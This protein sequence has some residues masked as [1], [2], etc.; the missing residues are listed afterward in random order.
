[1]VVTAKDVARA[2]GV[3]QATVSYV[4]NANPN[5]RISE[6]T[7]RRV[8][9]AAAALGYAPSAAA[10]ALRLGT[11]DAVLL[12]LPNIPFG[13][14]VAHII[15]QLTDD[16]E[17]IGLTLVTRRIREP[18]QALNAVRQLRPIAVI[19]VAALTE[20]EHDE[21]RRSGIPISSSVL[22][23]T[24]DVGALTVPQ[25]TIGQLQVE[26]LAARGHRVLGYAAP[27]DDR[28][29]EFLRLRLEGVR[30]AC[31]DLG[32]AQPVVVPVEL[33]A[34][35]G[36]AAV[37]AWQD[38]SEPITAI[39]A[40]ND[41]VA[42]AL[43]AGMHRLGLSAPDDFAVIGVDNV[44]LGALASPPLTTIDQNVE[45]LAA[46]IA[47]YVQFLLGNGPEPVSNG[48][49]TLTLVVRESA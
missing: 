26:H 10:R 44:P 13:H 47:A 24:S 37:R 5:Q 6:P 34:D 28:V 27:Q 43:L 14:T 38:G 19:D 23:P 41:D 17:A 46:R 18:G 15:E 29:S 45:L 21:I 11:S 49:D 48:E 39:C 36:A 3:S 40:Y 30:E 9:D 16:L 35:A 22:A 4:I 42:F 7:R 32:L 33:S 2:A 1:M 25:D 8:L 20:A 12:V 31:L